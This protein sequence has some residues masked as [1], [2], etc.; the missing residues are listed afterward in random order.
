MWA[1]RL[2]FR[3]TPMV[4]DCGCPWV[5]RRMVPRGDCSYLIKCRSFSN[6]ACSKP[7]GAPFSLS[8]F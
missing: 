4:L 3:R 2:W 6:C 1:N 7:L 5:A 8:Q